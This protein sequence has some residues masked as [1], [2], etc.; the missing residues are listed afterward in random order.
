MLRRMNGKNPFCLFLKGNQVPK[1]KGI[2]KKYFL[3]KINRIERI[4]SWIVL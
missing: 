1:I 2:S 3:D 4:K